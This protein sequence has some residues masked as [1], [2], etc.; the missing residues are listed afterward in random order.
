MLVVTNYGGDPMFAQR[1]GRRKVSAL[2][3]S[4]GI[5]RRVSDAT[6]SIP[7][8]RLTAPAHKSIVRAFRLPSRSSHT[9][10]TRGSGGAPF[11]SPTWLP[12]PSERHPIVRE[13]SMTIR[14]DGRS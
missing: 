7:V 12:R 2:A 11:V 1:T 10:H 13:E 14:T 9:E 3:G 6:G 4:A 5:D 8:T